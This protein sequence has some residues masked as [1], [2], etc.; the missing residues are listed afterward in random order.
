[1]PINQIELGHRI[2]RARE[3]GAMTQEEVAERL[4]VS[5][6]IVVQI[7]QGK[8]VVSGIEL[9]TLAYLF[10]RDIGE[11]LE[12][13][14]AE[15]D[16]VHALF[17][18]H[19]DVGED[20]V[21]QALRDCIALGHELTSLEDLLGISRATVTVATYSHAIPRTRWE[22]IQVG[23]HVAAEER[24]R[25]GLG[26]APLGDVSSLL[27]SQGIRTGSVPMPEAVSGLMISH[28]KV[29]PFVVINESHHAVRRRF[30]W[31][32]EY[33][34]V[35]LDTDTVGLVS[36][37]KD[38]DDLREVRANSFAA[39]FLMPE[40]GLRQLIASLGKG[41]E[42]RLYA[43][44]FDEAGVVP[45]DSRTEPGTQ[46]I[47]LYDVVQ[48]AHHYGVSSLS[49]L[50]RL[51][52]LKL[53]SETEFERLKKMDSEG[54][55]KTIGNLLGFPQ[56][57]LIEQR[58]EFQRR[59]L[60]LGLEALRREKISQSKFFELAERVNVQRSVAQGL[61]DNAGIDD[62]EAQPVLLPER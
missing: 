28:P 37:D 9:Q 1:M 8:R 30:S 27:E 13:E 21:K 45:I 4:G 40:D 10:A 42:S 32:H 22:A 35:L 39:N 53:L 2:R 60:S 48:L 31:C 14:F 44:I 58:G 43:E 19:E 50:Y 55:S 24:R 51:R 54:R 17:R 52:N 38:R 29:G 61:L 23:E 11:F 62:E 6:A 57:E 36:R 33:A 47:Q 16:V 18:C 41:A 12:E 56:L 34:H 25:L 5:R 15:D 49:T 20:G 26:S 3:A 7:E 46:E 59:F